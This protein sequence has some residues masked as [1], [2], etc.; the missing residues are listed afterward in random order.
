VAVWLNAINATKARSA[1]LIIAIP[2]DTNAA[3]SNASVLIPL[4]TGLGMKGARTTP[5]GK[6]WHPFSS[7]VQSLA[8]SAGGKFGP[9]VYKLSIETHQM[10]H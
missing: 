6:K 4:A 7:A 3:T 9:N 1:R 10:M 8:G 5:T 2:R